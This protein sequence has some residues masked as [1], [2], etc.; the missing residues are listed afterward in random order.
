MKIKKLSILGFKSFMDRLNINFPAGI[1]GVV[2]PNGCGKS[3]IVD[4]I[5]WCMGE[6]SPKQLRGRKM[7]DVIFNGAGEH[8]AMGMAEVTL[9]FENGDGSFPPA[10]S[11]DPELS[12]TRRLYRSGESDYMINNVPCRLKDIQE[13]FMDTGLGNR[14]YS[15]ISQGQIG[16]IIE[17]RPEETR[18]MLEEAAGITKYRRKVEASQRK[19]EATEANLQRVEDILGEV[20]KQMRSLKRQAAKARRY[21]AISEGIQN[22]ELTLYANSYQLY[23]QESGT[24][25]KS[26]EGLV[27]EEVAASAKL[28]QRQAAIEAMN[29]ELDEMVSELSSRRSSHLHLLEEIHKKEAG[30]ES[31]SGE[32]HMLEELE[33]R[34]KEEHQQIGDRIAHLGE[35]KTRLLG[36]VEELKAKALSLSEETDVCDRRL[37]GRRQLLKE[38]REVY[39]DA[40]TRLSAGENKEMGLT[41]ES[42][43]IQKMLSQ[44]TDSRTRLENELKEVETTIQTL[45][46]ASERKRSAREAAAH[47]LEETERA[48][49][50]HTR[51]CEELEHAREEL[52]KERMQ[53][54]SV[55]EALSK[56]WKPIAV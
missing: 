23:L 35:D 26:T 25:L 34:L 42:S 51:S 38:S 52:E 47:K 3:N 55:H 16:T 29:L 24:K 18:I 40:R 36:S 15:I 17:Q 21:K 7:E 45:L 2:G 56:L 9:V 5:R 33:G 8:K 27:Q 20:Q 28:S 44:I 46:E 13:I 14:A 1:S 4:A 37:K 12:V 54:L 22:L 49:Q 6:Q 30:L 43:Y 50:E 31:L 41:H 39:E 53:W 48:I 32:I 10:F 19:I 11:Q